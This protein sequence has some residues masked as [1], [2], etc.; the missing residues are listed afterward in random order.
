MFIE[1]DQDIRGY[2]FKNFRMHNVTGPADASLV[3][4]S[5]RAGLLAY[6]TAIKAPMFYDDAGSAWIYLPRKDQAN[7]WTATQTF[8]VPPAFTQATGTNP[9]SVTSTTK[10]ANLNADLLDGYD[11]DTGATASTVAI[12]DG[13][14]RLT[15]ADPT[16]SGH[17]V[18]LGFLATYVAGIRDPKDGCNLSPT[19]N[20][21]ATRSS[22]V[23]TMT[24][25]GALSI[26]GVTPG[27]GDRILVTKQTTGADNGIYVVTTVGDGSHQGV[28]TRSSD[29]DEN[30][31]VTN[32]LFTVVTQG[33]LNSGSEWVLT[34]TGTITVNT[35]ALTFKQVGGGGNLVV[36][37]GIDITGNTISVLIAGVTTYTQYGL[38]YA[39]GTTTLGQLGLGA[40]GQ[41]LHGNG[42]GAPTW[43]AVSLT[44]DVTGTLPVGNG[45]TGV[46]SLAALT[47]GTG[48]TGTTA[49]ALVVAA[50]ISLANTSVAASSYGSATQVGTFTVDAQGRLTAAGN[51]TVTPAASSITGGATLTAGTGLSGT[52]AGAVLTAV[53]LSINQ[54]FTPSWTGLHTWSFAT[55]S[56]VFNSGEQAIQLSTSASATSNSA[57]KHS[58]W[59]GLTASVWDGGTAVAKQILMQVQGISG[60]VSKYE[61]V[62][63]STDNSHIMHLRGDTKDA[64]FNG[65]IFI[66]G[67]TVNPTGLLHFAANS[68]TVPVIQF[69]PTSAALL[70][71]PLAGAMEVSSAGLLY[72]TPNATFGTTSDRRKVVTCWSQDMTTGLDGIGTLGGSSVVLTHNHGT[73]AICGVTIRALNTNLGHTVDQIIA[74]DWYPSGTN[75]VTVSKSSGTF[76]SGD[77]HAEVFA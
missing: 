28:L 7:S 73:K 14:G 51:T 64:L 50:T 21:V 70:T 2:Q 62:F 45:G 11:T 56:T 22:N 59:V 60:Q 24:S 36:G 19:G 39:T 69:T 3:T 54:A 20:L 75:T 53:S 10:V 15:F 18:T 29:C 32:G 46:T 71:T 48:L 49:G 25:N 8:T 35:T 5:G 9:F 38:V 47:A 44:A 41:V 43:S 77:Y 68:N 58:P 66:G 30:A 55:T 12:R 67:V 37:N 61:L 72:Y 40:T 42:S 63:K 74:V 34:T 65:N 4:A 76:A 57:H 52:T 16:S 6:D 33:T 23:L 1:S 17:G 26:D 13:S 31:E 27:V